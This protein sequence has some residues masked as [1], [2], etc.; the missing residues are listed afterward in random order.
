MIPLATGLFQL[1]I[2]PM[3][4]SLAMTLSSFTVV[5]NSLRLI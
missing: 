4:A 3:F 1:S 2:N 5:I